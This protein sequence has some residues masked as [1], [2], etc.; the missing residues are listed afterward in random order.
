[1]LS[2]YGDTLKSSRDTGE[3]TS[4]QTDVLTLAAKRHSIS[5]S[6]K[7]PG[8]LFRFRAGVCVRLGLEVRFFWGRRLETRG[9]R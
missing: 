4:R 9:S 5:R 3:E 6:E 8:P 1:M 2:F 7:K